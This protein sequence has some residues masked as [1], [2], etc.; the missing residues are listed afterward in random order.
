MLSQ[1]RVGLLSELC[2]I[3]IGLLSEVCEFVFEGVPNVCRSCA[4]LTTMCFNAQPDIAI[5]S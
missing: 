5:I 1:N 2:Q 4:E 3:R